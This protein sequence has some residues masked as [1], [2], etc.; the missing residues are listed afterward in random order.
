M[1]A[2]AAR[3]AARGARPFARGDVVL[4]PFPGADLQSTKTRPAVVVSEPAFSAAEG[5]LL[6]AGI[7]SNVAVHRNATAFTLPGWR[8]AGLLKPSVVTSWL[9]CI[10]PRIVVHRIGALAPSELDEVARRL[11]TALGL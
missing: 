7:T 3:R 1:A 5:R 2:G 4:V 8:R 11:R 6:I 10:A 9:A